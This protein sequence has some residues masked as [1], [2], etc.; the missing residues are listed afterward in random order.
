MEKI[1]GLFL[2]K[3]NKRTNFPNVFLSINSTC[4]GQFL[5][6]SSVFHCTFGTD[7]CY[8]GLMT[9][10]SAKCT[11]DDGQTNC[12]KHVEFLDKNKF[13][14]LVRLLV[15]KRNLLRCTVTCHDARSREC[16]ISDYVNPKA[17]VWVC[18]CHGYHNLL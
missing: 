18:Y 4:F 3:T 14:K 10:T 9:Y 12:P 13:G 11:P 16:K 1:A 5:C 2:F 17:W 8:A 6:P 15:L 7:I